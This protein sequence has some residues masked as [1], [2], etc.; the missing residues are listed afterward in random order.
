MN[1][2]ETLRLY[3]QGKIDWNAWAYNLLAH[4]EESKAWNETAKAD[5]TSCNFEA[6]DFS[7]FIFPGDALFGKAT[8]RGE[9]TFYRVTFEG[10]AQF[11]A[12]TFQDEALFEDTTFNGYANF[13]ESDLCGKL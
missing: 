8:F 7:E 1:K 3:K 4:R 9:T 13:Q 5:F 11:E 6:A 10:N 2:E 12:T